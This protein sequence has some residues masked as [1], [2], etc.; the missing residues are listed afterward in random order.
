MPP[1]RLLLPKLPLVARLVVPTPRRLPCRSIPCRLP[2]CR[3]RRYRR[4]C[5]SARCHSRL[6][7]HRRLPHHH[8][9]PLRRLPLPSSPLVARTAIPTPCRFPSCFSLR[10]RHL[11]RRYCRLT[12]RRPPL[13]PHL[14][15][16]CRLPHHH[17]MPP[18]HSPL[19]SFLLVAQMPSFTTCRCPSRPS[20]R[21]RRLN[22]RYPN[23]SPRRSPLLSRMSLRCRPPYLHPMPA[24]RLPLPW[25]PLVTRAPIP[26][27]CRHPRR[28]NTWCC[29]SSLR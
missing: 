29:R 12:R 26:T 11:N 13:Q 19:P 20:L 2:C 4:R 21:G 9:M 24:R 25:L 10:G 8:V 16:A 1:C 3:R 7:S 6:P 5:H 27:P 18:C 23:L 22:C 14:P 28:S 17:L 15:F